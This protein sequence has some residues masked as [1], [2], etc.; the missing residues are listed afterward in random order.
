MVTEA[1][2]EPCQASKM[3]RFA[4]IVHSFQSWT[5][6]AKHSVLDFWQGSEYANDLQVSDIWMMTE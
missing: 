3:K 1:Y 4:K 5:I 6:F 2:S